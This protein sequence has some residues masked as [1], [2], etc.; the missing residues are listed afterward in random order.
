MRRPGGRPRQAPAAPP[1]PA[2]RQAAPSSENW[3]TSARLS[4][5]QSTLDRGPGGGLRAS[6]GEYPAASRASSGDYPA[7][8]Q[9][10]SGEYPAAFQPAPG[11][12]A[13]G[14]YPA[15]FQ[16]AS[17]DYPAAFQPASGEYPD[18]FQAASGEYPDALRV[19]SGEQLQWPAVDSTG[20]RHPA[21]HEPPVEPRTARQS[22]LV[23]AGIALLSLIVLVGGAVVGVVYFSASDDGVDSVLELG[24]GRAGARTV[25]APLDNRTKAS[26]ELLAGANAVRVTIGE[27]GDELFRISTPDDAGFRPSPLVR[28]DDVKLQV[29]KDGDG[30]GGEIEVVLSAKVRWA[31]RFSGYAETQVIDV[32]GG[33]VSQI[34]MVAGMRRAEVILPRPSGT[35]P[36][37]INGAVDALVLKSPSASPVRIKVGGGAKTVV[38]GTR[39][40]KDVEAGSTLTPKGWNTADRYDVT[41]GARITALTIESA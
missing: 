34:E 38:A 31:L 32:S 21:H 36:L 16:S 39:T 24:A 27:L 1:A 15:A 40:L 35:V 41:A 18:A 2:A 23:T 5:E 3:P 37:R 20:E 26:F 6:S 17:G 12:P 7:V 13:S 8:F 22:R 25:T 29:T 14:E 19:P 10:A 11:Q 33:Q 28:N 4:A 9:P 30:T